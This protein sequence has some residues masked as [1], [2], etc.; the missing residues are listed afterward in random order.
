MRILFTLCWTFLLVHC[1]LAEEAL[2]WSWGKD[3]KSETD[4]SKPEE[5]TELPQTEGR[6]LYSDQDLSLNDTD[7]DTII[8]DILSSTRQGR[9]LQ[10]YDEVYT[11][12]DLQEA[13]QKGDN[14][15]ARNIIKEKLCSLGLMQ[16][17][18][19]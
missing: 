2:S 10:G 11:D 19:I 9:N 18:K 7:V 15:E 16:V 6:S 1:T 17:F 5:T 4:D 8:E 13:I 14:S 3:A 12:P